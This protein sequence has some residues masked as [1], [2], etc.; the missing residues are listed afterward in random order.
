SNPAAIPSSTNHGNC[1]MRV[2]SNG[3][4]V[5]HGLIPKNV[6][7]T[8]VAT[9]DAHTTGANKFMEKFPSTIS[10]ANTAPEIGALY[11]AAIPD[12]APHPTSM[13]NR[14]GGHFAICPH[15]DA[16]VAESCTMPP[17]RPIEPPVPIVTSDER[18][19]IK[20]VRNGSRPSPATTTSSKLLVPCFP[21]I[22][23]PKKRISPAHNPPIAGVIS[24]CQLP[25]M[26]ATCTMSPGR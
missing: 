19:F 21:T 5:Y 1:E 8:V 7:E 23:R 10:D 18:N 17:S 14:Y 2:N 20:P 26:I 3:G 9:T 25:I 24:R 13:R 11:A 6:R 15:F 16:S 4:T 12:A 22:R